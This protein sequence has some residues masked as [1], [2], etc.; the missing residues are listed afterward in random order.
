MSGCLVDTNIISEIRRNERA[1]GGVLAWFNTEP[2]AGMFLSV[3]TLGEIRKGIELL[4][5]RDL[6]Q[7]Q[8]LNFW[9]LQLERRFS[10]KI[11]PVTTAIADRWGRMLAIRP[12]PQVDALLAATAQEHDLTLVTRNEND[13]AGLGIR[14]FNPFLNQENKPGI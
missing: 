12:L 11:L 2:E 5:H 13:F 6:S 14:V 10:G 8:V 3:M 4:L 9:L 7:A 1:D